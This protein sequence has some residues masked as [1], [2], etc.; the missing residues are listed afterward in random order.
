MAVAALGA[1]A[2]AGALAVATPA[3]AAPATGQIQ[4]AAGAEAIPGSY[5]VV[6]KSGSATKS[7]Q[8]VGQAAS[9]LAGRYG[10]ALRY[11]YTAALQG[12]AATM[13]DSAAR[14]LA[15][16][17]QVA[18]VEQDS[19]V[20]ADVTQTGATWGIDRVD[21][22]NR[23]LSG[24]YTYN[25]T[26]TNVTA[27]IIDTGI[28]TT[29]NEFAG[30]RATVGT[31]AVGD[32]RNG[33]DCNGH[34]T[35]VSGTVGGTTFG[36]AKGVRLVA[37]R[38]LNCAGSGTTAG[39][40]A[41]IDFVTRSTARPAVANMSLG[42]GASA[43]LDAAV[44]R[45]VAAGVTYAIAAGNSNANACNFSPARTAEAI[46]VGATTMTDARSSFSNIGTCLDIFAPGSSITS[47][48][49]T[50]NTA[51]NTISGTSMATPHVAGAAALYL[52]TH[53]TASPAAVR[54]A[55]VAAATPSVISG[56]GTGSPNRLLFTGTL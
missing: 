8:A 45:S 44:R 42:G 20:H 24:T 6:L 35:H 5:I 17:P 29:H 30:G 55:L 4:L 27:F 38:V 25:T 10:G 26:A 34:G 28:R 56:A 14:Q 13:T 12:F 53:P 7:A 51:T 11:T 49:A 36:L 21:Q 2:L 15:A 43:T 39:V 32:G 41:G 33:Q 48:W 52:A 23:P 1:A 40:I 54:D 46:T 16:D 50:S 9:S 47:S 22:R 37:V 3:T 18:V 31:D 19:V